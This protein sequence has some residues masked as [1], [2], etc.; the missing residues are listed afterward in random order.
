MGVHSIKTLVGKSA[1]SKTIASYRNQKVA[2]DA[3]IYFYQ[4]L[5][6]SP[7][8]DECDKYVADGFLQQLRTCRKHNITP[9]YVFD[10]APTQHKKVL[11]DRKK[12][13]DKVHSKVDVFN[14]DIED[15]RQSIAD[16][17]QSIILLD[18]NSEVNDNVNDEEI[19][20]N[21]ID[22]DVVDTGDVTEI[23]DGTAFDASE[24]NV[25]LSPETK[26]AKHKYDYDV[27][28]R[29]LH[30]QIQQ[31]HEQ[32]AERKDSVSKLEK[33][34]RKPKSANIKKIKNLF[35][36]LGVPYVHSPVESDALFAYLQKNGK[37]DTI[38]TEDTDMLP[39]RCPSFVSGFGKSINKLSEFR[40]E[41][42]L[43]T[44]EVTYEQF[45]EICILC[46]CDYAGKIAHIGPKKALPLIKKYD[47]IEKLIDEY[48]KPNEKRTKRHTYS[49]D[50]LD[51]VKQAREM[52]YHAHHIEEHL[53]EDSVKE[54]DDFKW[55]LPNLEEDE[56]LYSRLEECGVDAFAQRYWIKSLKNAGNESSK[57][58]SKSGKSTKT[59]KSKTQKSLEKG[60][61]TIHSFFKVPDKPDKSTK[62]QKD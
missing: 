27:Q 46:G 22:V 3:S 12:Q 16:I 20:G 4:Y 38:F 6:R 58:S 47:T 43:R 25:D 39:L 60:Q 34:T 50:F 28:K 10:G 59:N 17:E 40:I 55:I 42:I 44:L 52:F 30:T 15:Y 45:V 5:Y 56:D 21:I 13:R 37:I 54:F 24:Q 36:I 1:L 19:D 61:K 9:I 57:K 8:E 18:V 31:L 35:D 14:K 29:E 2:V 49:D 62:K 41:D 26:R 32:I 33:Q 48:I 53:N 23:V 7:T 11:E 51:E